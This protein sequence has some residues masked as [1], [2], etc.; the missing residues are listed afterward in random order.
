MS[1]HVHKPDHD[2]CVICLFRPGVFQPPLSDPSPQRAV[3]ISPVVPRVSLRQAEI[4]SQPPILSPTSTTKMEIIPRVP[5]D[6]ILQKNEFRLPVQVEA[7]T[8]PLPSGVPR[9][10]PAIDEPKKEKSM[11][12]VLTSWFKRSWSKGRKY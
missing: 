9:S 1:R 6:V 5:A 8:E 10:F 11:H 2:V 12:R 7:A 4:S 3:K